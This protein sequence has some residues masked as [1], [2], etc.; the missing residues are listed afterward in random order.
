MIKKIKAVKKAMGAGEMLEN[1]IP[2]KNAQAMTSL[3]VA[4]L[5][6]GIVVVDAFFGIGIGVT[7]EQVQEVAGMLAGLCVTGYGLYNYISTLA[8]SNKVGLQGKSKP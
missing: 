5:G 3:I 2:W 8:T 4:L 7:D 1:P 6:A